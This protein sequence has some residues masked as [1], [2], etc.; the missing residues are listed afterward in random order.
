MS[1]AGQPFLGYFGPPQGE[2]VN[3]ADWM[4][5]QA[6]A[7]IQ[8]M[9]P[10]KILAVHPGN[11]ANIPTT[12]DVQPMIDQVDPAG[13]RTPHGTIYGVPAARYHAGGNLIKITPVV[14]DVGMMHLADRDASSLFANG[15]AQSPPGSSR[16]HD[17]ADGFYHG[18]LYTIAPTNTI[19]LDGGN[20]AHTTQGTIT[21]TA[22]GDISHT[23]QGNIQHTAAGNITHEATEALN[24]SSGAGHPLSLSGAGG[25][26]L[27]LPMSSSG[28]PSGAMWN[29]AGIPNIVP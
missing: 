27:N 8:V 9:H 17:M 7:R 15:G 14:G 25:L 26:I 5:D 20:M 28:L 4:I 24:L 23:S 16:R 3:N 13:N 6:A 29:N 1:N 12:V 18:G 22:K 11:N 19:D 10:V 2:E 21:H